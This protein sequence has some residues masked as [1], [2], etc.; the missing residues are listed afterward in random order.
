MT[1]DGSLGPSGVLSGP[2]YMIPAEMGQ[3]QGSNLFHKCLSKN[4]LYYPF[5]GCARVESM[6]FIDTNPC[7]QSVGESMP[8]E[9][10]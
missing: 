5:P 2:N 10:E 7:R 1:L 6:I 4:F 9:S 8:L 3:L